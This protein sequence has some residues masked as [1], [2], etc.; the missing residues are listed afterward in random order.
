LPGSG[1]VLLLALVWAVYAPAIHFDLLTWDDDI[2]IQNNPHLTGL[3]GES[4]KWIFTDLTYQ[5]RYQPLAWVTWFAIY[6]LQ[7]L[8]P[9]G[10]HLIVVL[11]HLA[12]TALVFLLARRLCGGRNALAL[13]AAALWSLHPM[14]VETVA[15]AVELLYV[16]A[17]FF[18]LLCYLAYLKAQEAGVEPWR[19]SGFRWGAVMGFAGSLFTFPLA[20]GFVPVLVATDIYLLGRL[21][22]SPREWG[23][24]PARR[25]WLEK[26]PYVM[27]TLLAVWLNVV[28][29]VSAT[30]VFM[31]PVSLESFGV[32]PRV[33]Q[34]FYVWAYYVW[35]PFWPVELTAVPTTLIEFEPL[36]PV[37]LLSVGLVLG[38][39]WLAF[40]WRKR[41]PALW[42]V[43]VTHLCLLVPML[44]LSEHPH[45]TSDRY[46]LIISIGWAL[47]L[48]A[49]WSKWRERVSW[50]GVPE[51]VALAMVF[52]LSVLSARQVPFW[53]NN[54]SFFNHLLGQLGEHPFR[55]NILWRLGVEHQMQGQW[56]KAEEYFE[57]ALKIQPQNI[58]NRLWLADE[59]VARGRHER[60]WETYQAVLALDPKT[61]GV[62]FRMG[63]ML[64]GAGRYTAAAAEFGAE[65]QNS[66]PDLSL[67]VPLYIATV[68]AGKQTE[69]RELLRLM[70]SR[71]QM[72][73]KVQL[74]CVLALADGYAASKDFDNAITTARL[75]PKHATELG[76]WELAEAAARRLKLWEEAKGKAQPN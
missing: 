24:K 57:N 65:L 41:W 32:F 30:K 13:L 71:F 3:S 22:E 62:H 75:V 66:P 74:E 56:G 14:R 68:R 18:L 50:R 25:I 72:P 52:S 61:P 27:L 35:R 2:N 49:G 26:V 53:T 5:Q 1:L 73:G 46:S 28:S 63:E 76:L 42:V 60:A 47:L 40:R 16:Q 9:F 4:L 59:Q 38:G 48:T 8:D 6:D 12:N 64:M 55:F 15:W 37:F 33:L 11:L 21:P 19:A 58:G 39:S 51:T 29:R 23:S 69:A 54:H 36:A 70:S 44:G 7:G 67:Y 20:F 43:W 34:G 45:M 10:Y 17:L 31:E